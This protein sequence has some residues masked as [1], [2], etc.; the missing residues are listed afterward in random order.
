MSHLLDFYSRGVLVKKVSVNQTHC[1]VSIEV[2][3][4]SLTILR[5]LSLH[6]DVTSSL[7]F[8]VF[9]GDFASVQL[10]YFFIQSDEIG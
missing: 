4:H 1:T 10:N 3:R 2:Y 5:K 6:C 7:K 8:I 9:S